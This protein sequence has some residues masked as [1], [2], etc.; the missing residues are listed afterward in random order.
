MVPVL[1]RI[2]PLA[3]VFALLVGL[4]G[5]AR[6]QDGYNFSGT[7]P[8]TASAIEAALGM[9]AGT[10]SGLDSQ[11]QGATEGTIYRSFT[12]GAGD[13]I[14]FAYDFISEELQNAASGANDVAFFAVSGAGQ[15]VADAISSLSVL[16]SAFNF[17]IP[18]A[19]PADETGQ[20]SFLHTFQSA[21]TFQVAIG[22]FD[23]TDRSFVSVLLVDTV[24]HKQATGALLWSD[25]F[26][27]G[28]GNWSTLGDT[29]Q[30]AGAFGVGPLAGQ[31]QALLSTASVPEPGTMALLAACGLVGLAM[32]RPRTGNVCATRSW[33]S[34]FFHSQRS[35]RHSLV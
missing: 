24:E 14:G 8:A 18:Q 19:A 30:D 17:P 2:R 10:L 32:H 31:Q 4:A 22:V 15:L 5:S 28:L 21:G 20:Q 26:E 25:G 35:A 1:L 11:G 34:R 6:A 7:D 29:I 3:L 12:V 16:G 33:L 23:V 13:T 9:A 27:S